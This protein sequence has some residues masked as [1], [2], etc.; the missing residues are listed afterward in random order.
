MKTSCRL[1]LIFF[2][3]SAVSFA[4]MFS[5]GVLYEN[6]QGKSQRLEQLGK[7]TG[8]G[9]NDASKKDDS[10]NSS[11]VRRGRNFPSLQGNAPANKD[12]DGLGKQGGAIVVDGV[13]F[14]QGIEGEPLPVSVAESTSDFIDYILSHLQDRGLLQNADQCKAAVNDFLDQNLTGTERLLPLQEQRRLKT[15]MA[16]ALATNVKERIDEL[17]LP[18]RLQLMDMIGDASEQVAG[19]IRAQSDLGLDE[20]AAQKMLYQ[21]LK[22]LADPDK[23]DVTNS[24]QAEG[25][26]FSQDENLISEHALVCNVASTSPT[27]EIIDAKNELEESNLALERLAAPP[28][29]QQELNELLKGIKKKHAEFLFQE[30]SSSQHAQWQAKENA[31][32]FSQKVQEIQRIHGSQE[33]PF[34]LSSEEKSNQELVKNFRVS[35]KIII[36]RLE[37]IRNAYKKLSDVYDSKVKSGSSKEEVKNML[38]LFDE[39]AESST[40]LIFGEHGAINLE[41]PEVGSDINTKSQNYKHGRT[42]VEIGIMRSF[43]I[44]GV[45]RFREAFRA[46]AIYSPQLIAG[47][48]KAFLKSENERAKKLDPLN[49]SGSYFFS[50]LDSLHKLQHISSNEQN[51]LIKSNGYKMHFNPF[52]DEQFSFDY[53][54]HPRQ[55]E[56]EGIIAIRESIKEEVFYKESSPLRQRDILSRYDNR[57]LGKGREALTIRNCNDF[58]KKE[59]ARGS[60][61]AD[62]LYYRLFDQSHL[63]NQELWS[64]GSG[65]ISAGKAQPIITDLGPLNSTLLGIGIAYG[66][67]VVGDATRPYRKE[68]KISNDEKL[69][70]QIRGEAV[71][72]IQNKNVSE[73]RQQLI[74]KKEEAKKVV[75]KMINSY[76]NWSNQEGSEGKEQAKD[77]IKVINSQQGVDQQTTDELFSFL[78]K[79]S[80]KLIATESESLESIHQ[81]VENI[82][83]SNCSEG[84]L[85]S[86]AD[87]KGIQDLFE[88]AKADFLLQQA[89]FHENPEEMLQLQQTA[90]K[91][92]QLF[93]NKEETFSR[94]IEGA[95]KTITRLNDTKEISDHLTGLNALKKIAKDAAATYT[96]L[97]KIYLLRIE[98]FSKQQAR[99]ETPKSLSTQLTNFRKLNNGEDVNKI[100]GSYNGTLSLLDPQQEGNSSHAA[101]TQNGIS[102]LKLAICDEYGLKGVEL[103]ENKVGAKKSL[104]L[105][106][107]QAI[108]NSNDFTVGSYFL[109]SGNDVT[110]LL[111]SD[112]SENEKVI[113]S[114]GRNALYNPFAARDTFLQYLDHDKKTAEEAIEE[115]R[116]NFTKLELFKRM[117]YLQQYHLLKRYNKKFKGE[118]EIPLTIGAFKDFWKGEELKSQTWSHYFYYTFFAPKVLSQG[119]A[120]FMASFSALRLQYPFSEF[121]L[122]EKF[123]LTWGIDVAG[124]STGLYREYQDGGIY[125]DLVEKMLQGKEVTAEQIDEVPDFEKMLKEALTKKKTQGLEND[126]EHEQSI[127][128]I[129]ALWKNW[130]QSRHLSDAF[131]EGSE[132]KRLLTEALSA[133]DN[134][135]LASCEDKMRESLELLHGV[136]DN[137]IFQS[138]DKLSCVQ[139]ELLEFINSNQAKNSLLSKQDLEILSQALKQLSALRLEQVRAQQDPELLKRLHTLVSRDASF[140]QNKVDKLQAKLDAPYI[141]SIDQDNG[142]NFIKKQISFFNKLRKKFKIAA[143]TA[144]QLA[145]TY[146]L[147]IMKQ[148]SKKNDRLDQQK[149]FLSEIEKC[150]Y[151]TQHIILDKNGCL[152]LDFLRLASQD[153]RQLSA[154]AIPVLKLEIADSLGVDAAQRFGSFI[155]LKEIVGFPLESGD[156]KEFLRI[157]GSLEKSSNFYLSPGHSLEQALQ[158]VDSLGH[159]LIRS[160]GAQY[161]YNPF[162]AGQKQSYLMGD[163]E[164]AQEGLQAASVGLEEM[165]FYKKLTDLNKKFVK[166][167]FKDRFISPEKTWA[168]YFKSF[169]Y[170]APKPEPLTRKALQD[171]VEQEIN[172]S[173]NWKMYY[174]FRDSSLYASMAWN[175][176]AG[177]GVIARIDKR[178]IN[179]KPIHIYAGFAGHAHLLCTI[180]ALALFPPAWHF[181]PSLILAYGVNKM[182]EQWLASRQIRPE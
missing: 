156:V 117:S 129:L 171:F 67:Q 85:C 69:F 87:V 131:P 37:K 55:T 89:R 160:N 22:E 155:K 29:Y 1:L 76:V 30:A 51:K 23:H 27:Q 88:N 54:T 48:V 74:E 98:E 4:Q 5:K 154:A 11:T 104:S 73:L 97:A 31:E 159:Q 142:D 165:P 63:I 99:E 25:E 72:E 102:L 164:T 174:Q 179:C 139:K 49:E 17:N 122:F 119:W 126:Q 46:D 9:Y 78:A 7:G 19:K 138:M 150:P 28:F 166:T 40:D 118:P 108:L 79:H 80:R 56:L 77:Y 38:S 124:E 90:A 86:N 20:L 147:K 94:I 133:I 114:N 91:N 148:R 15:V 177:I 65:S 162:E 132:N 83:A 151:S 116:S 10:D 93:L 167:H 41:Q 111:R 96:Q 95:Q 113:R 125:K 107:L 45:M 32:L 57:F 35:L 21:A 170:E 14:D 33:D 8:R 149:S 157:E 127:K 169:F 47:E 101:L 6:G 120:I 152:A 62:K 24:G 92:A 59:E 130:V 2:F 178:I 115:V 153:V 75:L 141:E 66:Q 13:L 58:L 123:A 26:N 43:G 175:I 110:D 53:F 12:A 3:L 44:D 52:S 173:E 143:E 121:N 134:S 84:S 140:Y 182:G 105:R 176:V 106:E 103:F 161:R 16:Q 112:D 42:L 135:D 158:S 50:A 64:L 128:E 34:W 18:T 145:D 144:T 81:S 39:V 172:E 68:L 180:K 146:A 181:A 168:R 36:S 70:E 109:S 61:W 136:A 60:A 82:S 137:T 71:L 100:I 163:K